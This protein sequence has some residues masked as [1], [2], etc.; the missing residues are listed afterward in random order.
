MTGER[1]K[2]ADR[3]V[4]LSSG[5]EMLDHLRD[6][7]VVAPQRGEIPQIAESVEESLMLG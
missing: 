5:R 4:G 1:W 7:I 6:D 2:Y 3:Q